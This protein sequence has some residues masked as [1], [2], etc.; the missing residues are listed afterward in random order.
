MKEVKIK[1][2]MANELSEKAKMALMQTYHE[3]NVD[4]DWF[5]PI[6]EGFNE[7]MDEYG[8]TADAQFSGF[9]SQGDGACFITETVDTDLLIRKLHEAGVEIPEDCLIYSKDLS[10]K[11]AKGSESFCNRYE[12][13]NTIEAIV[14]SES[15]VIVE[16]DL[17]LLES[18]VTE[19]ARTI[20]RE[21][22]GKLEKYYIELTSDEA[23]M[24]TLMDENNSYLFTESGIIIPS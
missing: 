2:F 19:W 20:S 3:I 17:D 13:E 10:I 8:I 9:W 15:D 5:Q 14:H 23:I 1:A 16:Y 12:H 22:Y 24:E 21:L 6:I 18:V 4:H 11:I 7:D